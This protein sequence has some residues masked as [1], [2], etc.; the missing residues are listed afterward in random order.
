MESHIDEI[1]GQ[2][3]K[4]GMGDIDNAGHTKDQG[5]PY[6]K[7]RIDASID[8]TINDDVLDHFI[9]SER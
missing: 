5:K 8:Q 4:C 1:S 3:V 9:S 2:H 6:C 7:E